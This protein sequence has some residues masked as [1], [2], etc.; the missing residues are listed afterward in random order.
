MNTPL[1]VAWSCIRTRSPSSA[2]PE[3][4]EDGSTAST[5]TRLPC[6]RYADTSAEVDVDLPTPGEP[7]MPMICAWPACGASAAITSRSSGDVVLDQRDEPGHRR[8]TQP[9]ARPLDQSRPTDSAVRRVTD[10]PTGTLAAISAS[11]WP[12]PPHSAAAPMPPPRRLQL[13][14]E[15]QHDPGAGHPDRVAERDRAAVDVDLVRSTSSSRALA[16]PTAANA[17]LISTRSRSAA[18]TPSFSQAFAIAFA[19]WLTAAWSPARRPRRAR[20]SRPASSGPAPRPLPCSSPPPRRAPSEIC[21]AEPAVIVPSLPN[22][23]RSFAS[24]STVVSP[25][26]PSSSST[27]TGSPLRCG[28]STGTTSSTKTPFFHASAASWCDRAVNCVLLLAGQLQAIGV[29]G[30]GQRTHRLIG[31]R[32][33][34]AVV[35]HVVGQRRRRRT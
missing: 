28:T 32:V 29:R 12:P 8:G 6:S 3:N 33:P 5:P 35:R 11:P 2:P 30:L 19:G 34:Q 1:S 31:E 9:L 16:M 4:G 14:R 20:R 10:Q 7:V 18:C 17:S 25:R 23:G 26:T 22:A 13:Q 15:V 27:T 24:A 21:D